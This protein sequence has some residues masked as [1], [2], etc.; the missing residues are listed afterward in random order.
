MNKSLIIGVAG[1]TGAGKTTFLQAISERLEKDSIIYIHH[2]SYYSDLNH[3]PPAKRA[4]VNFDH[5][6]AL[7]TS[8]LIE[9]L[10]QLRSGQAVAIPVYD[11]STHTRRPEPQ[12][13]EPRPVI[14]LEGILIFVDEALRNIMDIK[15][16]VDTDADIRFIRRLQ[17]DIDERGRT[18][19]SVIEQYQATVRPMHE[20]FVEPSKRYA[21][22]IIPE[23][24]F[25]LN[26]ID[27]VVARIEK[28]IGESEE[29]S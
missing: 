10:K 8:L 6:D 22:I 21:D 12:R 18:L 20:S 11:F 2:D 7:E 27:M 23:G 19:Q 15:I 3:L 26:A 4:K 14:V 5:P 17:R 24:G 9:H 29:N 25:N 16:Y 1:G 28:L 13:L